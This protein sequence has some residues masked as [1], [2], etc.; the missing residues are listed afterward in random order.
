MVHRV[1]ASNISSTAKVHLSDA[2]TTVGPDGRAATG[3]QPVQQVE[4][5]VQNCHS[6][7]RT[8][9]FT[10]LDDGKIGTGNYT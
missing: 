6:S 10:E 1:L 8:A 4:E 5:V 2:R 7:R 3:W 9:T